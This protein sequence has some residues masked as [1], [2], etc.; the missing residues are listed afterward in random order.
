MK[1]AIVKYEY[2]RSIKLSNCNFTNFQAET[3]GQINK[4][5]RMRIDMRLPIMRS[6]NAK[7]FKD[8]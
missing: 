2:I 6:L 3:N 7:F 5:I 4:N 8:A 1:M